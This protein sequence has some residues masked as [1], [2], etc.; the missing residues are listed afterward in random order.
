MNEIL[1]VYLMGLVVFLLLVTVIGVVIWGVTNTNTIKRNTLIGE[2]IVD[3][4]RIEESGGI[5]TRPHYYISLDGKEYEVSEGNYFV[6][7]LGDYIKIYESG[8]VEINPLPKNERLYK[9][10]KI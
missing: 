1:K 7:K 2:G 8:R 10:L 9:R 5:I 6:I 4:M 3:N